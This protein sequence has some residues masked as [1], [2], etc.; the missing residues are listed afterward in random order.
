MTLISTPRERYLGGFF[1]DEEEPYDAFYQGRQ[2]RY[3]IVLDSY[4]DAVA[5]RRLMTEDGGFILPL[6]QAAGEAADQLR[7]MIA[8]A[9]AEAE[10]KAEA[11]AASQAE[12][13]SPEPPE[14]EVPVAPEP[15]PLDLA[16]THLHALLNRDPSYTDY[17]EFFVAVEKC[18]YCEAEL[19]DEDHSADCAWQSARRFLLEQALEMH[20]MAA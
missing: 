1:V 18:A 9:D 15:A 12:V 13:T 4:A 2:A 19:A 11:E 20:E 8:K 14:E 16:L 6:S 10:A 17:D 7:E 3:I 5:W